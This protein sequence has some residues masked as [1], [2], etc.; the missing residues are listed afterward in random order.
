MLRP[1]LLLRSAVLTL[2]SALAIQSIATAEDAPKSTTADETGFVSLFD[3]ESLEGWKKSTENPDSWKVVDGMLVCEGKRCH[4][5][6]TGELAPLKNFHFKADV[7]LM[8]GSNAGIYFHT[9]YQES[10]WPKYGYECQ[11][12]VSHKDPKKTSSL[13]GVENV[14]AATLAANGIRDNEWY[15]Q[16]IIVR[17]KHIELKVNGKTLVNFTE[18]SDQNAFSESFERR[19]GE[20][21]FALQAHD[22]DSKAYF[23]NLRVKP[24]DE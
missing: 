1:H 17:G 4:L 12:N 24:L 21:T 14:D 2:V 3:G 6:Y 20:G 18:P 11:V 16:E 7:K 23:K 22:P 9:K 15:T 13:Y 10:G 8:P 19:L 5:F